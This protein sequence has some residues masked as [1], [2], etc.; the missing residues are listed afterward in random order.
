MQA[1][2]KY[3]VRPIA[4]TRSLIY[5]SRATVMYSKGAVTNI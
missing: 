5:S 2:S 1:S 4:L 3:I